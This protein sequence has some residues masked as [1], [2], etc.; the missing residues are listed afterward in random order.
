MPQNSQGLKTENGAP[1]LAQRAPEE[2]PRYDVECRSCSPRWMLSLAKMRRPPRDAR[3]TRPTTSGSRASST[4]VFALF[5]APDVGQPTEE[6][7]T[8]SATSRCSS[9]TST[10]SSTT[11][12]SHSSA[13]A[14]LS[15]TRP[16]RTSCRAPGTCSSSTTRRAR[17]PAALHLESAGPGRLL[18]EAHR[19]GRATSC[20]QTRLLTMSPRC[21]GRG[22][23]TDHPTSGYQTTFLGLF[24]APEHDRPAIHE[25]EIPIIQRDFAQGRPDDETTRDPRSL[26]R[27]DRATPSRPTGTWVSTSSTAT[28]RR[29]CSG[30]STASSDLRL[31]SCSTG[32]SRRWRTTST[33]TRRGCVSHTRRDPPRATSRTALAEHPYPSDA[34]SPSAW[35]TDQPWYVY[36]WRQDPTIA[37]MLVMLDAIHARLQPASTDFGAVWNGFRRGR[38]RRRGAI[39]FLF[40][41]VVDTDHGED[42]YIKM[43]SRGKPLTT[44]EVF[45]ADFESIMKSVDPERHRH[46]VDSIDGSGP[47]SSGSTKGGTAATSRSTT[48]SSGT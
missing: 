25:I 15:S 1:R 13:S 32:T 36:P 38:L 10:A 23:M 14:S 8:A 39:W 12:C 42:L 3:R 43:N 34:A 6:T 40:L 7:C 20:Y 48:S 31:C 27:C 29:A 17:G 30:R 5:S 4:A 9:A 18:R 37:S 21:G 35:I 44:F 47:T 41:P 45:K 11:R 2:D 19:D 46:L 28:S 26:P 22:R 24:D 33:R 16:G